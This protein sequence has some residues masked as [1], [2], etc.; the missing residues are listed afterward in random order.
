MLNFAWA[1]W[2]RKFAERRIQSIQANR[3][4]VRNRLAGLEHLEERCL[5]SGLAQTAADNQTRIS[6]SNLDP[7]VVEGN[8]GTA[9]LTLTITA[10]NG[11]NSAKDINVKGVI[12]SFGTGSGFAGKSDFQAMPFQATIKK[13]KLP[14]M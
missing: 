7:T 11:G 5:L 12:E 8:T 2:S 10:S 6:W 1:K 3:R 9:T 14:P 4:V 13:G